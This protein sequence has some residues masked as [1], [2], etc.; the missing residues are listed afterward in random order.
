MAVD[1][2]HSDCETGNQLEKMQFNMRTKGMS[3]KRSAIK[4]PDSFLAIDRVNKASIKSGQGFADNLGLSKMMS[5]NLTKKDGYKTFKS[6]SKRK[7]TINYRSKIEKNIRMEESRLEE[8][9]EEEDM[10]QGM[11]VMAQGFMPSPEMVKHKI[12]RHIPRTSKMNDTMLFNNST[13]FSVERLSMEF[14]SFNFI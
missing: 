8:L 11:G 14:D 9:D 12:A 1:G 7:S 10:S 3:L 6:N 5:M 2:A 4:A 13:I